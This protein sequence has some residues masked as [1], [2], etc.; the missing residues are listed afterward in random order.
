MNSSGMKR[1]LALSAISALA[2]TGL[3]TA[4]AQ[5]RTLDEA[6]VGAVV[7]YSPSI[8]DVSNKS[9]GTNST[10]RLVAAS[11]HNA[12]HSIRFESEGPAGVWSTI[13]TVPLN[14]GLATSAFTASASILSV[15]AVTLDGSNAVLATSAPRATNFAAANNAITLDGATRS[16]VGVFE[17]VGFGTRTAV[18]SGKTGSANPV[19]VQNA[20]PNAGLA[21][22]A[23]PGAADAA[24]LRNFR[25]VVDIAAGNL[26]D[27]T[28][29]GKPS[30]LDDDV[31]ITVD[32][33][34]SSD[35]QVYSAYLQ[36]VTAASSTVA[37]A[38]GYQ[39]N[40]AGDVN[41]GNY[42]AAGGGAPDGVP[43]NDLT[44]YNVTVL[45]QNGQP[46]AGANVYAADA[47]GTYDWT[48]LRDTA[49]A[50]FWDTTTN[51][52]GQVPVVLDESDMDGGD[53]K[54]P[55]PNVQSAYLVVDVNGDYN[56]QNAGDVLLKVEQTNV[57]A[58][59]SKIELANK[60]G[61]AQDDDET[62]EVTITVT[63][64]AGNPVQNAAP[65][66][67]VTR[68]WTAGGVQQTS[69]NNVTVP[70]TDNKGRTT[71]TE[72]SGAIKGQQNTLSSIKVE[73]SM[74]NG[75]TAT[76]LV[77]ESDQAKFVWDEGATAQALAGSTTTQ[78][79]KLQLPSGAVLPGRTFGLT[80]TPTADADA[81]GATMPPTPGDAYFAPT[82][83]QVDKN[84]QVGGKHNATGTT[85]AGGG[86]SVTVIDPTPAPGAELN[87]AVTAA[88]V[89]LNNPAAPGVAA[90]SADATLDL[91]FLRSLE[92]TRI[93]VQNPDSPGAPT[94]DGLASVTFPSAGQDESIPGVLSRGTVVAFNSD[95]VQLDSPKVK[96]TVDEGFFV[97]T[98]SNAK[99]FDGTPKQG[100]VVDYKDSGQS[101]E[102]TLK[103]GVGTFFV[104]IE[105]N[106]GFDDDGRVDDKIRATSGGASDTHDV[107]W[108]TVGA[109]ANLAKTNPLVV[110]LSSDQ[111]ST[112][113]PKA[114]AAAP[115][116]V[117]GQNVNYDVKTTDFWGNPTSMG[118]TI[119]DNTPLAH[120]NGFRSAFSANQ[121]AVVAWAE[122]ATSQVLEVEADG[123]RSFT[124]SAN[125]ATGALLST[126]T[127]PQ[128][129]VIANRDDVE[130]TTSAIQWYTVD[131][132]ASTFTLAQQG[133][134]EVPVGT[135]VTMELLAKDQE[136]QALRGAQVNFV[137]SGPGPNDSDGNNWD[138]VNKDG[139][140][141]YDFAGTSAGTASVAAIVSL[142]G[143]RIAK[144]DDTVSFVGPVVTD[145][146]PVLKLTGSNN[147]KQADELKV[148]VSDVPAGATVE[149]YKLTRK[150]G[151]RLVGTAVTDAKGVATFSVRDNSKKR[152]SYMARSVAFD[153]D[154][155]T[156][157]ASKS[158]KRK[159]R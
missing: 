80:F 11:S 146:T 20:G 60:L 153:K 50:Q 115:G 28:T 9:D 98:S 95:G 31:V 125:I 32:N 38:N 48:N 64:A 29:L 87:D 67:K 81:N 85:G 140:A 118:L 4:P 130:Q 58:A 40:V 15:R 121:P 151:Q 30:D 25:A 33:G 109:P 96:L 75:T 10:V 44:R 139:K 152:T 56:F 23:T 47:A 89:A 106:A 134:E 142:N 6:G 94:Q 34:E 147:G 78:S 55:A 93:E 49:G 46:V 43:L 117:E 133:A 148:K 70:V 132:A 72:A 123:A 16:R 154:G 99:A 149:L 12:A 57:P 128:A 39:A 62:G 21:S 137:R 144:V 102:V 53:D 112:V 2:L 13:A 126:P 65:T 17:N 35:A 79:G 159:V 76:P 129:Y 68:T 141:F 124:Y 127:N 37:V 51:A 3:A 27:D 135:T 7:L 73:V 157:N 111:D 119:T 45:D 91:D 14:Q 158:N 86:F 108:T 52:Q 84:T 116:D 131:P 83:D 24:G 42:G 113:L 77:I 26:V 92:A 122:R 88:S 97:D 107:R 90:D 71:I 105:R 110:E 59:A 156:Y 63:D 8:A 22:A 100:D 104:T 36:R 120:V 74:A 54:N 143:N 5:A 138:N 19:N 1:G 61:A 41:G 82:A 101:K 145:I 69:V 150:R 103:D 155:V 114:R 18:V 66:V 136:E